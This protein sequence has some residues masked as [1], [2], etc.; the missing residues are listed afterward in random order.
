LRCGNGV[1]GATIV[2]HTALVPHASIF[3]VGKQCKHGPFCE[4][5]AARKEE[6]TLPLCE[7]R[8]LVTG[9]SPPLRPGRK[10]ATTKPPAGAL[11]AS[12]GAASAEVLQSAQHY[13]QQQQQLQQQ[14]QQWEEERQEADS[15]PQGQQHLLKSV[16]ESFPPYLGFQPYDAGVSA[17]GQWAFEPEESQFE[18]PQRGRS[19]EEVE[20]LM[21]RALAAVERL[22]KPKNTPKLQSSTGGSISSESRG[23]SAQMPNDTERDESIL[24]GGPFSR[25]SSSQPAGSEA[26]DGSPQ[27][28]AKRLGEVLQMRGGRPPTFRGTSSG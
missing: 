6:Q 26:A 27:E 5:C 14:Q 24:V 20:A 16:E 3:D 7:C 13:Q 21:K 10:R 19:E 4:E 1:A 28:A 23:A 8:A 11:G 15:E 12:E 22:S 9:W 25:D 2:T 18:E 17:E